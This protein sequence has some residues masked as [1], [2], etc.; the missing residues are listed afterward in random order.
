MTVIINEITNIFEEAKE[1]NQSFEE[2]S[3][4]L[5]PF[6]GVDADK[7]LAFIEGLD[8]NCI[9]DDEASGLYSLDA[10]EFIKELER[11]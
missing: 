6:T 5:A 9:T 4:L 3:Q 7:L 10:E 2:L 1:A 8:S 11:I